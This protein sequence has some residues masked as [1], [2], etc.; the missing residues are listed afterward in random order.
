MVRIRII[1]L[2]EIWHAREDLSNEFRCFFVINKLSGFSMKY[3]RLCGV[4]L[5]EYFH[6]LLS[7]SKANESDSRSMYLPRVTCQIRSSVEV[8]QLLSRR[9]FLSISSNASET[10]F[11]YSESGSSRKDERCKNRGVVSTSYSGAFLFEL[12]LFLVFGGGGRW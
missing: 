4:I 12:V 5:T 11:S 6:P 2:L 10:L 3:D 9:A 1:Q 8:S 7:C